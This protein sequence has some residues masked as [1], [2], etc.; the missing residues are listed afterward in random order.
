[1]SCQYL[2]L[3]LINALPWHNMNRDANG[4]PKRLKQGGVER[5]MLSSQSL[6]RAARVAYEDLIIADKSYRSSKYGVDA[7]L[8]RVEALAT[9]RSI[10]VDL[11]KLRKDIAP[12]IEHL[13]AAKPPKPPKASKT[14]K[15]AKPVVD[16]DTDAPVGSEEEDDGS[17]ATNVWLSGDELDTIARAAL[18]SDL[19]KWLKPKP[20]KTDEFQ[21]TDE[22][23]LG[24]DHQ[25]GSLAIAAFGRMFA[26]ASD[27]QTEAA[28]AVSPAT[29]THRIIIETDYFTTVDDLQD[30]YNPEGG[31]GASHIGTANF[32][33]GV[34]YRTV[35]IDREQL[36]RSW[37]GIA[38]EDADDRLRALLRSI[39]YALPTGKKNSAPAQTRPLAVLLEEQ[40]YRAAYE[41]ETPV[42]ADESTDGGYRAPSVARLAEERRAAVAFDPAMFGQALVAGTVEGLNQFEVD[43][44]SLDGV[45][46][47]IIKW[48]KP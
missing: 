27:R 30:E 26:N 15:V 13:V 20:N 21:V 31:Q 44:V 41:F 11:V 3:H 12:V 22:H 10:T 38:S 2:T 1:M 33:N 6:K 7:V 18:D 40:S 46:E 28:I 32:T 5:A 17:A 9:E 42:L 23:P 24:V 36:N 34:Y 35:T 14:A 29:T 19:S 8:A 25:V 48:L 16:E 43:V 39:I 4:R 47:H 37:S 45:V